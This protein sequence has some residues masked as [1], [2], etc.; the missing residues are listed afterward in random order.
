MWNIALNCRYICLIN[1]LNDTLYNAWVVLYSIVCGV[2]YSVMYI[3]MMKDDCELRVG[4]F[5]EGIV[6]NLLPE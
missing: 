3:V 1:L 6:R 5:V 2:V 4:K